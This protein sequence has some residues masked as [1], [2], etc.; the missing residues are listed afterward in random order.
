MSYREKQL[1]SILNKERVIWQKEIQNLENSTDIQVLRQEQ[2]KSKELQKSLILYQNKV[3]DLETQLLNLAQQ[4]IKSKKEFQELLNQL[5][6]NQ[7]EDFKIKE[8][9][10]QNTRA[11]L[12]STAQEIERIVDNRIVIFVKKEKVLSYLKELQNYEQ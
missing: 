2:K 1:R 9:E 8:Q 3:K 11:Y 4:K 10:Y 6:D 7:K 12:K 5:E